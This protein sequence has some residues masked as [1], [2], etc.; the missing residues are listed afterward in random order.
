MGSIESEISIKKD[1]HSHSDSCSSSSAA[2]IE[3]PSGKGRSRFLRPSFSAK[4]GYCYWLVV[5]ASFSVFFGLFTFYLPTSVEDVPENSLNVGKSVSR[6]SN[7]LHNFFGDLD[8]G[9]DFRFQSNR[10]LARFQKEARELNSSYGSRTLV[11]FGHRKPLLALVFAD[12]AFDSYQILMSTVAAALQEIGYS[13]EVFSAEDGP[14]I[15]VW[16]YLGVPVTVLQTKDHESTGIDWLNYLQTSPLVLK[17]ESENALKRIYNGILINSLEAKGIISSLMQEPFKSLPLLWTVNEKTLATRFSKYTIGG[18]TEILNDWR[19]SFNRATVVV[20][21]NYFLPIMYSTFDSGNYFVIPGAPAEACEL[22][23]FLNPNEEQ[24]KAEMAIKPD[25][26]VIAI[27]GSQFLYKGLWLEHSLILQALKPLLA[28]FLY[29]NN[30]TF[31]LKILIVT[32]DA[33]NNYTLAVEAISAGLR[34]PKDTVKHFA[35]DAQADVVLRAASV[36][37]YGS[38]LEEQS[39]PDILTKALCFEKLIIAPD[40]YMIEKYVD[41]RINGYIFPKDNIQELTDILLHVVSRG[42]LTPLASNV[43]TLGKEIVRNLMVSDAV[44]GYAMLLENILKLP[45][46]VA[47]A[48]AF[49]EIP[50]KNKKEWKW[51]IFKTIHGATYK[52]RSLSSSAYLEKMEP[53]NNSQAGNNT[54][55]L[56]EDEAFIH[57][58]W[59]EEKQSVMV[60]AGK[61]RED[62]ELKDRTEQTRATWEEVYRNAKRADRAKNDLREREDGE[63]ERTGQPLSIYEP[64]FGE[65]TWPF[66]HR[67]SLYRGIGLSTRGRRPGFDDIDAS[68]RLPLLSNHYYRDVLGEL[69]AFFAIAHK[70][71]RIHKNAW[72]GFQSW[73]VTA[74]KESLSKKA[75]AALLNATYNRKNGDVLYFWA[76]MDLDHRNPRRLD[77][78]SFCDSINAGN[79]RVTFSNTLKRMYGIND[80]ADTLPPMPI[81]SDTWSVM[82]SWALPTRSFLEFVMF[83]RMFVDEMDVQMYDEH[84]ETGFCALSLTKDKHCYSRVLE[85]IVNMWAY[86]S[87]RKMVYINPETG[88]M[89]DQHKQKSR[90]GKMWAQWFSFNTLKSMDEDLA[91]EAD[92]GPQRTRWLW[93][94]TG[95]VY[96]PGMADKE[97][98]LRH[99]EKEKRRQKS[100]DK[101]ERM[102][103]RSHQKENR[104]SWRGVM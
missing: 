97:R 4:V 9:E 102:K 27:V 6:D 32:G 83:A 38:F 47:P 50:A 46:E 26:F 87:A 70:V 59:E 86:H 75:E 96:W 20:F 103:K 14:A 66:L 58:I 13:V 54:L 28:Q 69:G 30:S 29:E 64:Y 104:D 62:E 68:S 65:G 21:P 77:F 71:D 92:S 79:C 36:V 2:K 88:V 31:Q 23:Q 63:L 34:Y 44:E 35:G 78:W 15:T 19:K 22:S 11:R 37:I 33:S 94:T 25:D 45:S 18:K 56:E 7:F 51:R 53:Q 12:L 74:S 17:M 99:K 41:D 60:Y 42:K 98:S 16:R 90:K 55:S 101:L 73:R 89:T 48:R 40:L 61:R 72:I 76:R 49:S 100:R 84:H 52:N 10:V 93:P 95:E 91:E 82:H 85:L 24:L 80:S 43:A 8:F 3:R 81:S 5:V 67:T 39:F 57:Q 1:S